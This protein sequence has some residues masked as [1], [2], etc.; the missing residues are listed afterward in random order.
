MN[1][2]PAS[3]ISTGPWWQI[4]LAECQRE[5]N[6]DPTGWSRLEAASRRKAVGPN[7][8]HTTP[9]MPLLLQFLSRFMNPL[10]IVLLAAGAISAMTGEVTSFTIIL[11]I[12]I[13]SVTLDSAQEYRADRAADRLRQSV[14][15]RATVLRDGQWMEL[16]VA[17]VVP[18]DVISLRAGD[19][20]PADGC[21]LDARDLYVSR[22]LLTGESHPVEKTTSELTKEATEIQAATNAVFMGTSVV[23][24]SATMQAVKTGRGTAIGEIAHFVTRR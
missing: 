4:P 10:V 3:T 7:V 14:A 5:L 15:V 11:A 24:G 2:G 1:P 6:A 19:L 16:T 17:D 18:G 8:F 21:V 20:V 13:L 22:A 23:S 9:E 12:V